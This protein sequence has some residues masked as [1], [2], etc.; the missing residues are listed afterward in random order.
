MQGCYLQLR[1]FPLQGDLAQILSYL[2]SQPAH[3][4]LALRACSLWRGSA[5][6]GNTCVLGLGEEAKPPRLLCPIPCPFLP[7]P[8]LTNGL[9]PSVAQA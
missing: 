1:A 9:S 2:L 6:Q 8:F 4:L 5:A 7:P 3:L